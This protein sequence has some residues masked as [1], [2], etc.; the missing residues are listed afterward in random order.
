M[1]TRINNVRLNTQTNFQA[2]KRDKVLETI[3]KQSQNH[4][5]LQNEADNLGL[6]GAGI[7]IAGFIWLLDSG[8]NAVADAIKEESKNAPV[9]V[10]DSLK[11][12]SSAVKKLH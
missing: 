1:I 4:E 7:A 2:N 5:R 6:L 8:L 9:A 10:M 11:H 3:A 12:D